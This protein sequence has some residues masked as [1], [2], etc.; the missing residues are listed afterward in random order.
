MSPSE[1]LSLDW[2]DIEARGCAGIGVSEDEARAIG[3]L[4]NEADLDTL[5][6]TD[7]EGPRKRVEA[8]LGSKL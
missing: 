5:L 3:A 7:G 1:P 8:V 2:S 4:T 6:P